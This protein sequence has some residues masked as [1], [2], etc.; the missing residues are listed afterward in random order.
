MLYAIVNSP[1]LYRYQELVI[2]FKNSDGVTFHEI[3]IPSPL[4]EFL[5]FCEIYCTASCCQYDA[6]E[7]HHSLI[8]RKI[9]DINLITGDG[10]KQFLEAHKQLKEV[11][12]QI[13]KIKLISTH[14]QLSIRSDLE[15]S[16][17][18]Y[19]LDYNESEEWFKEWIDVFEEIE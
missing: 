14:D 19:Q 16:V 8:R 13:K 9:I 3:I 4:W 12:L 6:F 18:Q 17:H 1:K 2:M 10:S 5:G 15:P 7:Q 11:A